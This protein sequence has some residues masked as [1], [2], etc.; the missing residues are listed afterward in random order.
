LLAWEERVY[1]CCCLRI[2]FRDR[3][4]TPTLQDEDYGFVEREDGIGEQCLV[5]GEGERG[6][7]AAFAV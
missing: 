6:A 7:I 4:R 3:E 2:E 5:C 1:D